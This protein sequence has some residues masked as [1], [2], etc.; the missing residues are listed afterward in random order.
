MRIDRVEDLRAYRRAFES[1]MQIFEWSEQWPKE[2]RY[3]LT[4]QVRRS[5]RAVCANLSESW[6]KRRYPKHFVAKLSDAHGEAEETLT[7]LRFAVRCHYFVGDEVEVFVEQ[8][9]E[10]IGGLVN[11]MSHPSDWSRPAQGVRE[12]DVAYAA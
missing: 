9:R 5:S 3:A 6:A 4:D 8:Y 1:A 7:W 2:E 10:V 12:N 11:M